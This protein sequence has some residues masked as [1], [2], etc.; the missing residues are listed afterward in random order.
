MINA[1]IAP[2]KIQKS[3]KLKLMAGEDK[4]LESHI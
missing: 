1:E 4:K 3:Y 2:Q